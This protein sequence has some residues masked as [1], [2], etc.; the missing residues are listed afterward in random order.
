MLTIKFTDDAYDTQE[1][2]ITDLMGFTVKVKGCTGQWIVECFDRDQDLVHFKEADDA[3]LYKS[4]GRDLS[5]P[6]CNL[7]MTVL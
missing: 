2:V 6:P 4:E 1:R 7:K 5:V 3:G